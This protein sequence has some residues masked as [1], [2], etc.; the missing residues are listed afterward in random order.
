MIK[1]LYNGYFQKSRVFL[2]PLLTISK[3]QAFKPLNTYLC[4][5]GKY[6]VKDRKLIITYDTSRPSPEWNVFKINVL[7]KHRA[8]EKIEVTPYGKITAFIF[9]YNYFKE[10]YDAVI[11][12]KY[13]KISQHSRCL[14]QSFYGYNTPEWAYI[15][16]FLLPAR[17]FKTYADLLKVDLELLKEVGELTE[18]PDFEKETLILDTLTTIVE[19]PKIP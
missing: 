13:S 8:F 11:N 17:H 9:D 14:I 10:D 18:H 4:W 12:G 3:K 5:K 2:Y 6:T 16:G 7:M 1:Q 15:E 19:V